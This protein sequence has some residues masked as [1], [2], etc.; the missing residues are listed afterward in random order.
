MTMP[1]RSQ[2]FFNSHPFYFCMSRIY[3][4]TEKHQQQ[5]RTNRFL[6]NPT[7][8]A[9]IESYLQ[10]KANSDELVI[11]LLKDI[12][13][14]APAMEQKLTQQAHERTL[15]AKEDR[16]MEENVTRTEP[17]FVRVEPKRPATDKGTVTDTEDPDS[18]PLR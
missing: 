14:R 4:I 9:F 1:F 5:L 18:P 8:Q 7:Q 10:H 13:T 16:E 11:Q 17:K 6:Q 2:L 3:P 12:A 15:R